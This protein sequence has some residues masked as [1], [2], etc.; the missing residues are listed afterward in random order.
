MNEFPAFPSE[1]EKKTSEVANKPSTSQ[2]KTQV[3][4]SQN[5]TK[6]KDQKKQSVFKQ[7]P[8]SNQVNI[9]SAKEVIT[10]H[11]GSKEIATQQTNQRQESSAVQPTQDVDVDVQS[12][13]EIDEKGEVKA[14]AECHQAGLY[15]TC[16][17]FPGCQF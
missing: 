14:K 5:S 12:V 11:D 13:S 16:D 1:L 8:S 17:I 9:S 7:E 3:G 10:S 4:S 6:P 2:D 15:V